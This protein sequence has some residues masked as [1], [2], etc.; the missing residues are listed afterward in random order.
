MD[1]SFALLENVCQNCAISLNARWAESV[2]LPEWQHE[3]RLEAV[4]RRLGEIPRDRRASFGTIK[5]RIGNSL[6]DKDLPLVASEMAL[7][8]LSTISP[9]P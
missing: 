9:A 2:G 5:A 4:Q 8:V 7:H 6:P 3:H 1:A